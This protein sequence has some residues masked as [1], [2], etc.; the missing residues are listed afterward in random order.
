MGHVDSPLPLRARNKIRTRDAIRLSAMHLF[1]AN[2]YGNTTVEQIAEA[3]EVSPSTFFRYF[4]SKQSV[5][6]INDVG[7]ATASAL[8]S[9]PATLSTMQAFRRAVQMTTASRSRD[10]WQ[11]EIRRRALVL[12]IPELVAVHYEEHRRTSS[13]MAEMECRRLGRDPGDFEVR[14]FF[15]ALIGALLT[16]QSTAED[17][18]SELFRTL[19]FVEAGMPLH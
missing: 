7:E 4:P 17:W 16:V 9:Q 18:R 2:G 5:L 10:E 1:E 8:A 12:S 13:A 6:M 11:F 3:A 15:G 14:V 19:D